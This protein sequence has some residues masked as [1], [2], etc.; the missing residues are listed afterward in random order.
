MKTDFKIF[1][2]A[3]WTDKTTLGKLLFCWIWIPALPM[4]FIFK[5]L[6]YLNNKTNKK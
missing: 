6:D 3:F 5:V 4:L 1:K 2:E